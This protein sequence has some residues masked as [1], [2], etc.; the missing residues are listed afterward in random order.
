M[1]KKI[2]DAINEQINKELFSGYLYLSMAAY[3]E[4]E[5]L[6]GIANWLKVQA[7]EEVEHAMRFYTFVNRRGGVVTLKAIEQPD[8]KFKSILDIFEKTL[9]HEKKVTAMINN[10]FELSRKENDYAFE[11][12]LKWF[13]D[14]QV[15]EEEHAMDLV[16]KVKLLGN[17]PEKLYLLDKEL[18]V[19]V[20]TP[21]VSLNGE[22]A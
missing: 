6:S 18:A 3:A 11:S 5:G 13:I 12:L 19:R 10:L 22:G 1:N 8:T 20:Y 7:Q 2:Q 15:E 21:P 9:E 16:N 14:E 17:D 4:S